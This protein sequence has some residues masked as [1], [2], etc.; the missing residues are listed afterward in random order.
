MTLTKCAYCK[1][2]HSI[3]FLFL[4]F[5]LSFLPFIQWF[6]WTLWGQWWSFTRHLPQIRIRKTTSFEVYLPFFSDLFHFIYLIGAGPVLFWLGLRMPLDLDIRCSANF[7]IRT[8]PTCACGKYFL[9]MHSMLCNWLDWRVRLH[10]NAINCLQ[11][12]QTG[13][14]VNPSRASPM[15]TLVKRVG[16]DTK[17]LRLYIG[18]DFAI[19]LTCI[20]V[21]DSFLYRFPPTGLRQ[22]QIRG[23]VHSQEW[24][25]LVGFFC[26]VFHEDELHAQV[27]K[28]AL[29]FTTKTSDVGQTGESPYFWLR[30]LRI[31]L[32]SAGN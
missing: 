22:R 17:N 8:H 10:R 1:S 27:F 21:T 4:F 31:F 3:P 28:D 7:G 9:P 11:F 12:S 32:R 18:S 16:V 26:M 5:S 24:E 30:R 23:I 25:R 29:T 2:L 20:C 13:R 14:F 15:S 19:C 6:T